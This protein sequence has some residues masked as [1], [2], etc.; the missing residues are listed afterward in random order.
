MA[1]YKYCN[2]SESVRIPVSLEEPLMP[3]TLAFAIHTLVETRLDTSVFD[4]RYTN[5][6]T[7][8][9]AYEP[10]ILLKVVLFG[11]SRGLISSRQIE[12]ACK[13]NV[14]F[15]ALT[16][17]E[18]SDH[19]RIAAFVSSMKEEI[20]PMFRG[21]LRVC[22]E[23]GLLGGTFFALDGCKLPSNAS[24]EWSGTVKDLRWKK[25]KIEK[26]VKQLVEE[27]VEVDRGDGEEETGR[28]SSG[29]AGRERQIER[30]LKKAARMERWLQENGPKMGRQGREI[31]S[32][33]TDNESA[34]M[35]TSH[36]T[37]QGYNGQALVDSKNQVIIHAEAFGEAQD[38]HL[39]PPVLDGAREN[40][41]AIGYGEDYFVGKTLTAD[42]NYHSPPNLGKCAQEGLDAYIPDKRF[43]GRDSRFEREHKQ[44][45]RR[46]DRLTIADF[47]HHEERDE[48]RCP[49]GRV[50]RLEVKE[51]VN[52]GVIY[53]RY[54]N[55]E[56]GCEGCELKARCIRRNKARR[57]YV[58]V[59]VG[60]VPGRLTKTLAA[61]IDSEKGRR[62][63]HRR[64]ATA[65]PVFANIRVRKVM[66]RFTLRGRIKV[67]IQWLLYCMVP[68]LRILLTRGPEYA[69]T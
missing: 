58:M 69:F 7:G 60:S 23:E 35:I 20:K 25:G 22:E 15:M 1:K 48:Y 11:Y 13:E 66:N 5:D 45:Q 57:R 3:G 54:S 65:E 17:G 6:E 52:D 31:K 59:P 56:E 61:K 46:T 49:Q 64:I 29:G 14:T 26:K 30:L 44:R 38:L 2:Y 12:R 8:R 4:S 28:R 55:D 63:Y 51:T 47:E 27:Q 43:R 40:M 42:S 34:L 24:K 32:N 16:C 68:N 39:I 37:I 10:K 41:R 62:I 9:L 50:F 67:N 53:R 33:V 19:S 21:V 18:Q 36:G